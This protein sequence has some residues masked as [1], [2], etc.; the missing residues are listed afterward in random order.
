MGDEEY[1]AFR[2]DAK[3]QCMRDV[4]Q[5]QSQAPVAVAGEEGSKAMCGWGHVALR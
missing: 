4:R 3:R 2:R 1:D 5:R